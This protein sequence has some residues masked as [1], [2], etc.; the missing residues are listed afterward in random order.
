MWRGS[1]AEVEVVTNCSEEE[2]ESGGLS[3]V[4]VI[5]GAMVGV[6]LMLKSVGGE[7]EVKH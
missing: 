2:E 1:C 5:V 7:A 6:A 4:M 3:V